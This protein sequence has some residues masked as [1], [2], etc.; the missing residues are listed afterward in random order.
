MGGGGGTTL[1]VSFKVCYLQNE[2][3][4]LFVSQYTIYSVLTLE[5]VKELMGG[6]GSWGGGVLCELYI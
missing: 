1:G 4:L 3:E 2:G 6:G 5:N